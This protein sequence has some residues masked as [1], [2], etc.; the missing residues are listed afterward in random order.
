MTKQ[1]LIDF[2]PDLKFEFFENPNYDNCIVGVSHDMRPIYSYRL[3]LKAVMKEKK[4][5]EQNAID[6][7]DK[8]T[9]SKLPFYSEAPVILEFEEVEV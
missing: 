7:I 3:M 9:L 1:D 2:F 5:N 4:M 8:H 6:F